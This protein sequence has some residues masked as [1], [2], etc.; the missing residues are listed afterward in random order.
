MLV[1]LGI[2]YAWKG[3]EI[4]GIVEHITRTTYQNLILASCQYIDIET[5]IHI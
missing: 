2:N 4:I 5:F 3:K 1:S